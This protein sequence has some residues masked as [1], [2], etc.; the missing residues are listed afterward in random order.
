M[1]DV[2]KAPLPRLLSIQ[3]GGQVVIYM[4]EINRRLFRLDKFAHLDKGAWR[5]WSGMTFAPILTLGVFVA[6]WL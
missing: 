4:K 5:L 1:H 3:D 6:L 2:K